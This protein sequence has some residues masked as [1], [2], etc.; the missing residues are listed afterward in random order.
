[1][2]IYICALSR[3]LLIGKR[4]WQI[5]LRPSRFCFEVSPWYFSKALTPRGTC[6]AA[7]AAGNIRRKER[8]VADLIQVSNTKVACRSNSGYSPTV[9]VNERGV[10]SRGVVSSWERSSVSSLVYGC[11]GQYMQA[12]GFVWRACSLAKCTIASVLVTRVQCTSATGAHDCSPLL[13]QT[14]PSIPTVRPPTQ[15]IKPRRKQGL[16]T[17][18]RSSKYRKAHV[19]S[20][21]YNWVH[22]FPVPVRGQWCQE[23]AVKIMNAATW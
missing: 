11:P 23:I 9:K 13:W 16:V 15:R 22:Q 1:M 21:C 7:E 18:D 4:D 8:S 2:Y 6:A 3:S 20:P 14:W 19:V 5:R 10:E 12:R 17:N